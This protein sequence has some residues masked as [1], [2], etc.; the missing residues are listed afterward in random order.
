MSGNAF[1]SPLSYPPGPRSLIPGSNLRAMQRDP[2]AFLTRCAHEY[3]DVVHFTFGPQHLYFFNRPDLIRE[4]LVTQ[5]SALAS[6]S[7]RLFG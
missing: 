6:S 5:H 2:I 1:M 3:G 4:L 7:P